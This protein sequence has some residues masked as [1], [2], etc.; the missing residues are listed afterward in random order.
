MVRIGSTQD[1]A[2]GPVKFALTAPADAAAK[3]R[4]VVFAQ[5]SGQGA[6]VGAAMGVIGETTTSKTVAMR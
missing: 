2:K 3:E 6:V 4:V 1:L 5:Q